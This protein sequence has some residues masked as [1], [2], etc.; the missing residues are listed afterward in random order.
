MKRKWSAIFMMA[1][2]FYLGE[3]ASIQGFDLN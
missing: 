3:I 1:G 2:Y